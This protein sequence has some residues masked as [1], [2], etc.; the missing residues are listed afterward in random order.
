MFLILIEFDKL[1]NLVRQ[2]GMCLNKT[3]SRVRVGNH[4]SDVFP[5]KK[6]LKQGDSLSSLLFNF[7]LEYAMRRNQVN[8]ES[9]KLNSTH[10]HLV[11]ADDVGVLNRNIIL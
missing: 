2:T 10:Q 4:W 11:Q 1:V 7:S 6:G 9:L 5:A 3:Y 8:Q